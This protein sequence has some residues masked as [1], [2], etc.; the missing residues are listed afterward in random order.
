MEK[1]MLDR[2]ISEI[3]FYHVI[4]PIVDLK[5]HKIYGYEVLIRADLFDSPESLFSYASKKNRLFDLD[6]KSIYMAF[7]TFKRDT[8]FMEDAPLFINVFPSTLTNPSFTKNLEKILKTLKVDPK[9][10]VFE[11]NRAEEFSNLSELKVIV[12]ELREQGF[13]IALDDVGKGESNLLSLLEISPDYAKID[14]Y[15]SK[16]LA[17]NIKKQKLIKLMQDLL[18]EDTIMILEGLEEE[19][20]LIKAM[21]LDVIY[22]QGYFLGKPKP[23][24]YYL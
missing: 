11:I 12:S 14:L 21:D 10:I 18:G 4:Q 9:S 16:D 7:V 8:K 5:K 3:D 19:E 6:M 15:F 20:D 2:I 17:T 1:L 13:S 23:L 24:S 22:G